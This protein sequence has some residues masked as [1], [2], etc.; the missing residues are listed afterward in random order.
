MEQFANIV[1]RYEEG[2]ISRPIHI[3]CTKTILPN[4]QA[5]G[6]GYLAAGPL[7]LH[8]S[9]VYTAACL[10]EGVMVGL[11]PVRSL[12]DFLAW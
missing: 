8:L 1:T 10:L 12:S 7:P 2:K 4:L 3:V 11:Y 9:P 6:D 5:F